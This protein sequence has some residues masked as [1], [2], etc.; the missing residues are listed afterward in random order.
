V[1]IVPAC[2]VDD[3]IRRRTAMHGWR[4]PHGTE[5]TVA[6]CLG[7]TQQRVQMRRLE[8]LLDVVRQVP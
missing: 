7:V 1:T 5:A 6:R 2:V 8:L 4:W 3:A